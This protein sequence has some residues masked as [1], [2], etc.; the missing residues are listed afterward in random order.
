MYEFVEPQ[1]RRLVAEQLGVELEGL[2]SEVSLREDL[3]ADSLDLVELALAL[4]GEFAIVVPERILD[5]VRSFGDLVRATGLLIRARWEAEARG[6]EPA[7]R[8]RVRIVPPAGESGGTLERTG[9]LTPYSAET[10]AEDAV[11]AGPRATL[12]LAVVESATGDLARVERQFAGLRRRGVQVIVR[13]G[14]H[15]AAPPSDSFPA[16]VAER[17]QVEAVGAHPALT[18]GLLDRMTGART[19]V[20]VTDYVGDDPW[21]A[22]DLIACVGEEVKRFGDGTPSEQAEATSGSGPCQFVEGDPTGCGYRATTGAHHIHADLDHASDRAVRPHRDLIESDAKRFD[23]ALGFGKDTRY[24]QSGCRTAVGL[25]G[26]LV[27]WRESAYYSQDHE[28]RAFD[29]A[30]SMTPLT[31][32]GRPSNRSPGLRAQFE[33]SGPSPN[34][35][36]PLAAWLDCAGED[37]A[38]TLVIEVFARVAGEALFGQV[39]LGGGV[40]P[41]MDVRFLPPTKAPDVEA[42]VSP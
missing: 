25:N 13:R 15:P 26:E 19:T 5:E 20:T 10:I 40:G 39:K 4:E 8:I 16:S 33:L 11:R 21:Q 6:A 18:D 22:D 17:H 27:T 12:E 32:R 7:Q 30:S 36:R 28:G 41:T 35:F 31:S 2:V 3:A 38:C 34:G 1:V 37:G 42:V 24:Y 9:W 23:V 29:I 14:D